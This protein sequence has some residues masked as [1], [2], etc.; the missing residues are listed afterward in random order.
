[1]LE[2]KLFF[3]SKCSSVWR[4]GGNVISSPVIQNRWLIFVKISFANKPNIF[5]MNFSGCWF[6]GTFYRS[7]AS[8]LDRRDCIMLHNFNYSCRLNSL[9]NYHEKKIG[10][11]L[12]WSYNNLLKY[13]IISL[14]ISKPIQQV[15]LINFHIVYYFF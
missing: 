14:P 10:M 4:Y 3:N 9:L 8:L 2:A 15:R 11:T 5:F 1:M 7:V 6:V 12:E 13:D